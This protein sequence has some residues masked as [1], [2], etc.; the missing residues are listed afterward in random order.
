MELESLNR[1]QYFHEL[2]NNYSHKYYHKYYHNFVYSFLSRR[3]SKRA[4]GGR[5]ITSGP[6]RISVGRRR[7]PRRATS[8]LG[9]GLVDHYMVSNL[10]RWIGRGLKV[11]R[12]D[13]KGSRRAPKG[14]KGG[15]GGS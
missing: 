12:W 7:G 5:R 10:P 13:T 15:L 4:K 2:F 8:V 9:K 6:R 3:I 11:A 1:L 14:A